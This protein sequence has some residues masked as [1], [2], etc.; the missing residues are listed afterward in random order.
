MF[1]DRFLFIGQDMVFGSKGMKFLIIR[2]KLYVLD[3]KTVHF[4]YCTFP[5]LVYML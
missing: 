5:I 3:K 2:Q 4:I 1:F